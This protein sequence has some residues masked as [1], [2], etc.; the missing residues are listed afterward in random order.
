MRLLFHNHQPSVDGVRC[1]KLVPVHALL[2]ANPNSTTQTTALIR[3]IIP[4]LR[5]VPGL[6]LVAQHTHYPGHGRELVAGLRRSDYDVII[7]LGGDGTVNEVIN[8]L[9]GPVEA[10]GS[11][12]DSAAA[13]APIDPKQLPALGIIPTG[14]ANVFARALGFPADPLE[15]AHVLARVLHRGRRRSVNLGTW[16]DHWFAVNAGFGLDADVLA[17]VDRLRDRGFSATPLRYLHISTQAYLRARW[18]PPR[19]NAN[20]LSNSGRRLDIHEAPLL[21]ASNTNPWTFLGPLPMVTN[22]ENSFDEGLGL[23]GLTSLDGLS[24]IIGML[25]LFGADRRG[26]LTRILGGRTIQF[27]DAAE[28]RLQCPRPHRFQVDGE[29]VGT[30]SEVVLRSVPKAI[31]VYAPVDR[32]PAHERSLPEIIRDLVRIS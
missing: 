1:L 27:D 4:A 6:T 20:A 25:H 19:I 9:L 11:A 10:V 13:D 3:Q 2:I 7:V 28:I 16:N 26:R 22:P 12:P 18:R 31:E 5:S 24:G 8:G 14:S 23:F 15:A 21:L 17:R 29:F 32:R 30:L